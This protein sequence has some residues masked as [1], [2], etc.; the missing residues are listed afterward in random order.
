VDLGRLRP[1]GRPAADALRAAGEPGHQ[2]ALRPADQPGGAAEGASVD[3]YIAR[4]IE[5]G[6]VHRGDQEIAG[7]EFFR[8]GEPRAYH[9]HLTTIGSTFWR[10]HLAFRD[11]LRSHPELRDQYAELKRA[12]A[13]RFP[14]DREAY[15]EGKG[16]FVR[17][18]IELAA[19]DS[20]ATPDTP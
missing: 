19:R 6:Y 2:P 14:G 10:E 17:H 9:L 13:T 18:V 3:L 15:I 20:G 5:S 7:R 8:R 4:L 12:L 16:P 11:Y 1:Q